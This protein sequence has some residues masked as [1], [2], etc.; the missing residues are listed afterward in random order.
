MRAYHFVGA[1]LRDGRPVPPDGEWLVHDGP[2]KMCESGLHASIHP[3]DALNYAPGETLCLV[4]LDGEIVTE[5]DKSVATKRRI[6]ARINAAEMLWTFARL[7]ASGVLHRWD[8]PQVVKDYL[9]TGDETLRAAARDAARDAARA[10]A[11]D[12]QNDWLE[13]A[14]REFAGVDG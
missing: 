6:V 7:C 8:A 11:R 3:F 4:D 14:V 1:T 12:A 5:G 2:L 13:C 9:T 10:A